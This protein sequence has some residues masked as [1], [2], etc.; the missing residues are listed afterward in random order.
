MYGD[1]IP[2]GFRTFYNELHTVGR[3]IQLKMEQ[4]PL[5]VFIMANTIL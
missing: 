5:A 3:G 1:P 2:M 4:L